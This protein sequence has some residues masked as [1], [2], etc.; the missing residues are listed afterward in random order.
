MV[1]SIS[2]VA[3]NVTATADD[4]IN[5]A[6]YK[7]HAR[8]VDRSGAKSDYAP[9]QT[10]RVEVPIQDPQVSIDGGGCQTGGGRSS[11]GMTALLGLGVIGLIRRRRRQ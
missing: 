7:W 5:G 6:E 8:A 2:G 10:F 11:T 3:G 1:T 9:V 4:L